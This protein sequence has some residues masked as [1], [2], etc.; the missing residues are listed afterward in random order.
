MVNNVYLI[1]Y[2]RMKSQDVHNRWLSRVIDWKTWRKQNN[3]I[4]EGVISDHYKS[5]F[6]SSFDNIK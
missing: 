2:T 5:I 4:G 6:D 1:L 3:N